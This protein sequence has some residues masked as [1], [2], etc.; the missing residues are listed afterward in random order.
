MSKIRL[1]A[2]TNVSNNTLWS[3]SLHPSRDLVLVTGSP[4]DDQ[5]E[6]FE[7]EGTVGQSSGKDDESVGGFAAVYEIV[8]DTS[9]G[10]D[11][12][13]S[14]SSANLNDANVSLNLVQV[15]KHKVRII[16]STFF[17]DKG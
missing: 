14:A 1:L 12:S 6:Y 5:G 16:R 9:R 3:L 4:K 17:I 10:D 13:V 8:A 7:D 15:L 11:D 2:S